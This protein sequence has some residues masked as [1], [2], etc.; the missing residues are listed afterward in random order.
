MNLSDKEIA[1]LSFSSA[2]TIQ[3]AKYRLKKKFLL[4]ANQKL[5]DYLLTI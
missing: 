3:K 2:S 4:S 1:L 5:F